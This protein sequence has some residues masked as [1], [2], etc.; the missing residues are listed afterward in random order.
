MLETA[1]N[2][3]TNK[4]LADFAKLIRKQIKESLGEILNKAFLPL[5]ESILW[6]LIL[7]VFD[8]ILQKVFGK[9]FGLMARH[10]KLSWVKFFYAHKVF[11]TLI[12]FLT[13]YVLISVNPYVF[14]RYHGIDKF[15]DKIIGLAVIVLIVLFI[16]RTI[17]AI[18][19][20]NENSGSSSTVGVRTVGQLIKIFV[21]FFGFLTFI[22]ILI[23][24]SLSQIFTVLGALT[25]VVLLIFRDS[26]L[27]FISGLQISTTKSIKIGDWISMSKYNVEGIIREINLAVT[28][29]E[30][31]DKTV[32]T[33]PT[34]D[35]IASEV[36][37]HSWMSETNTRRIKRPIVFNVNSFQFC[38]REFLNKMSQIELIS[39]YIAEKEAEIKEANKDLKYPNSIINGRQLTNIGL[40]RTYAYHYLRSRKDVSQEDKVVVRQLTLT[41]V[42]MPLEIYCFTND[43][44]F[45]NFEQ[46]QADI[47]DHLIT[48]SKEFGL[49]VSQP[50][51]IQNND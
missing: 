28:K 16:F 5:A 45:I 39:D 3:Y 14:Q 9:I 47:F 4:Y 46:I 48:A 2:L 8:F 40:F 50:F 42:G 24:V 25:A 37:N 10:S 20:I 41:N 15:I 31:F 29:I 11:R 35:L 17:D 23:N 44:Q 22:A 43:S 6:I 30:K 7:L 21:A 33:V 12:H 27:G 51:I 32:S 36:T 49:E 13:I 1:S 26:I 38:D 19:S 18:I 34:Y